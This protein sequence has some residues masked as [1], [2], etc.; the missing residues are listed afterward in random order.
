MSLLTVFFSTT[1]SS[2]ICGFLHILPPQRVLQHFFFSGQSLSSMQ[3]DEQI[4]R[5]FDVCG[6]TPAFIVP[7]NKTFFFLFN[8]YIILCKK[9]KIV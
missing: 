2:A 8:Y 6:Q 4:Q 5:S 3:V 1:S 7:K 9:N